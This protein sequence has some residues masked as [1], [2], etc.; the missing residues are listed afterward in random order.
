MISIFVRL[1]AIS[2]TFKFYFLWYVFETTFSYDRLI[3]IISILHVD[4]YLCF[5]INFTFL[6][7]N[8]RLLEHNKT[9]FTNMSVIFLMTKNQN[10]NLFFYENK[11]VC[12][13]ANNIFSLHIIAI[14]E[15]GGAVTIGQ[16]SN[17]R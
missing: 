10:F 15:A 13:F 1:L 4:L 2:P 11:F 3:R 8:I 12:L 14:A 6:L 7:Y 17:I 5:V 9:F 16:M